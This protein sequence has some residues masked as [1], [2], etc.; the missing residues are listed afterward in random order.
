MLTLALLRHAKSSWNDPDLAD[1]DRPLTKRGAKSAP[2]MGRYL[3]R[4][5]IAP[6]LVLCSTAVRTRATLALLL[7]EFKKK[8]PPR[9]LYD[10]ALY[11]A[12]PQTLLAMLREL[13]AE[14]R[15]V[16]VIGHNPGLHAM[17]L[18]L[19]GRGERKL[20]GA[21]AREFPTAALAVLTFDVKDWREIGPAKGKLTHFNT[22]RRLEDK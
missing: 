21:M 7:A 13:P 22:P 1:R 2:L 12:E 4:Q 17:A 10:E 11:L 5:G 8:T 19:T 15:T 3:E 16:L 20:I 14:N 18:E 6:D 9:I